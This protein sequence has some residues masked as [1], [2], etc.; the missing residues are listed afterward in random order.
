VLTQL[1]QIY[2]AVNPKIRTRT[3]IPIP[4]NINISQVWEDG[5]W[6]WVQSRLSE[7]EIITSIFIHDVVYRTSYVPEM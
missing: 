1:L 3:P 7:D 2:S 6:N 4:I 5:R